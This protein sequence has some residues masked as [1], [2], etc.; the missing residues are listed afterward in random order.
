MQ[1]REVLRKQ[2][3]EEKKMLEEE[4]EMSKDSQNSQLELYEEM[5][6]EKDATIAQQERMISFYYASLQNLSSINFQHFKDWN[7]EVDSPNNSLHEPFTVRYN[8]KLTDFE[9]YDG[10]CALISFD[11]HLLSQLIKAFDSQLLVK[12]HVVANLLF[13]KNTKLPFLLFAMLLNETQTNTIDSKTHH[14]QGR[15]LW[16]EF[17]LHF[18]QKGLIILICHQIGFLEYQFI[19]YLYRIRDIG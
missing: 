17:W 10:Q 4:S 6:E 14:H 8:H 1:E 18:F 3:V 16:N 13:D 19:K 5:L 2:K 15:T 9:L 7:L 11:W 12:N